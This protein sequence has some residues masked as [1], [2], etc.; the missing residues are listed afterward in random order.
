MKKL[1]GIVQIGVLLMTLLSS[2]SCT[3]GDD[4]PWLGR[5]QLREYQYPDGS[6]HKVDSVFYGF[7]KGS[8]ISVYMGT[9]G[10]YRSMY[11]YYD[12]PAED[13]LTIHLWSP[14]ENDA[15]YRKWFGWENQMRSFRVLNL[16]SKNMK[17]D[18]KDT[19][20]VF[21]LY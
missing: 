4:S 20:Y 3:N 13:S 14:N 10:V 7:Q 1:L 2:V 18:Y 15:T 5:W 9:D 19:V 16:T 17:L 8:F 11:G 6:I 21:R 12:E